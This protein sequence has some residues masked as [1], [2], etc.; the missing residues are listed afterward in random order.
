MEFPSGDTC[1]VR[2]VHVTCM[3]QIGKGHAKFIE[4]YNKNGLFC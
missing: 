4:F 2:H 3:H 1:Y